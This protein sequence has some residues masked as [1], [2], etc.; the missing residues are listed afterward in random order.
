MGL[1]YVAYRMFTQPSIP[2]PE[3]EVPDDDFVD[4][5]EVDD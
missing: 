3:E 4:Y 5:E 1:F 2:P